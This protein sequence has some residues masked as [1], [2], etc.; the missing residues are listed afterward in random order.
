MPF[1]VDREL[2]LQLQIGSK[3]YP[4]YPI[5]S[6]SEAVYQVRKALGVHFGVHSISLNR[7]VCASRDFTVV[8]M[9]QGARGVV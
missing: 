6:A 5:N 3:L 4:D 7:I 9:E 2:A 8:G 1:Y